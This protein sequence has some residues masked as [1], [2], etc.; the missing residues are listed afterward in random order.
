MAEEEVS[1]HAAAGLGEHFDNAAIMLILIAL[2]VFGFGAVGRYVGNKLG[3]P[4][5]TGFFGG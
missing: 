4:G 3:S 1:E 2:F 5:V